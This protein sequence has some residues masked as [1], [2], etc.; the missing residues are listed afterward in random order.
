MSDF[1]CPR[2]RTPYFGNPLADTL[3][4]CTCTP[5]PDRSAPA[6][7]ADDALLSGPSV[8]ELGEAAF[9]CALLVLAPPLAIGLIAWFVARAMGV[10]A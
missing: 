4:R 3:W 6:G 9:A 8:A 2:C 1:T 10:G 5:T 7:E